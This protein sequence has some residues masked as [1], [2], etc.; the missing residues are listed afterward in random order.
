MPEPSTLQFDGALTD[1]SIQYNNPEYIAEM[2]LPPAPKPKREGTYKIYDKD[3]RFTV[4]TDYVGHKGEPREVEWN[5]SEGTY[6]CVDYG[7]QEFVSNDEIDNADAPLQP[8]ADATKFV[9]DLLML[10]QEMGTADF[11]FNASNYASGNKNDEAGSWATLSTDVLTR[12]EV[13]IDAC[14]K[15]PTILVMGIETWRKVAR[16]T[17]FRPR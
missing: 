4:P 15:P 3:E 14:F 13:G 6:A 16:N 8:L 17:A 9:T 1:V 11:V 12:L 2:V 10:A 7:L 5:V